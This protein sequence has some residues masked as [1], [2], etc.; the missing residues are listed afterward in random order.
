[1]SV[2]PMQLAALLLEKKVEELSEGEAESLVHLKQ[3]AKR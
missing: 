3:H 1:V 2:E